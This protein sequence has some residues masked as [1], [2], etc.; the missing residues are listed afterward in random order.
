MHFKDGTSDRVDTGDPD[1]AEV[2]IVAWR[3]DP[4]TL[5]IVRQVGDLPAEV[6][7]ESSEA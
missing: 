6:V 7:Y 2:A 5:K 4:R 1:A 3:L